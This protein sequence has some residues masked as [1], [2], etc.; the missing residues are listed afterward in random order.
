[1]MIRTLSIATALSLA[2]SGA[3]LADGKAKGKHCPPGLQKKTPACV[4]PGLAKKWGIGDRYDGDYDKADWRGYRLPRPEDG[5]DWIRVGDAIFK[6]NDETREI[7]TI[8]RLA[9]LVLTDG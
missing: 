3:A 6:V 7:L 5:E 1:M 8:I 9:E 4:P 2:L